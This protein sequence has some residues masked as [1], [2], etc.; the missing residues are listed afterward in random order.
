MSQTDSS[1]CESKIHKKWRIPLKP[2]FYARVQDYEILCLR[3]S[4]TPNHLTSLRIVL[5]VCVNCSF[6][7]RFRK[8]AYVRGDNLSI[9]HA[10]EPPLALEM[11]GSTQGSM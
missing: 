2:S 6:S 5:N 3:Q 1:L 7:N 8:S 10:F 9:M 4:E 11:S